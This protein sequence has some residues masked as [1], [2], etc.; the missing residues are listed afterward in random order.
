MSKEITN[1][2][3]RVIHELSNSFSNH[4]ESFR[5]FRQK[6]SEDFAVLSLP[7][8]KSEQYLKIDVRDLFQTKLDLSAIN[9][10]EYL[11]HKKVGEVI[12]EDIFSFALHHKD[13]FDAYFDTILSKGAVEQSKGTDFKNRETLKSSLV[14]LNASLLSAGKVVYVPKNYTSKEIIDLDLEFEGAVLGCRDLFILEDGASAKICVK[15]SNKHSF[16]NRV[17]EVFLGQGASLELINCD[18]GG[19]NSNVLFDSLAVSQRKDSRFRAFSVN[20]SKAVV[21]ENI[22]LSLTES[23]CHAELFGSNVAYQGGLIST[24]TVVE[25]NA[26]YCE[27]YEHYKNIVKEGSVVD[28]NGHI[29]VDKDAQKTAAFQ[30]NN[31][32]VLDNESR[33]FTKPQLEIYADDVKC[34]HGA[35]VG[36]INSDALF[37]LRQR[38]LSEKE[39]MKLLL[40]GF[41]SEIIMKIDDDSIREL[42]TKE[43]DAIL[44]N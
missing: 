7:F 30:R 3:E 15:N 8:K 32:I 13:L 37:Y 5:S 6:A 44:L 16:L 29:F 17:C 18:L 31:N 34:S 42:I 4:S 38:G 40:T 14:L 23:G 33:A 11:Y 10:S 12:I 22:K 9:T 25:H 35:T 28:F 1:Q 43:I 27:S 39:A 36:Q 41:V 19:N 24:M 2:L 26:P 21:R 20:A